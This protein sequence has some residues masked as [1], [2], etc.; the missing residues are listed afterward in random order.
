[1]SSNSEQCPWCG[2]QIERQKFNEIEAKIR[3]EEQKKLQ[4][5]K[6]ALQKNFELEKQKIEKRLKDEASE[7]FLNLNRQINSYQEQIKQLENNKD[8]LIKQAQKEASIKAAEERD[9]EIKHQRSLL[10]KN[11]ELKLLKQQEAFYKE[12]ENYQ[13]KITELGN[14]LQ[15]KNSQ[16]LE[17]TTINLYEELQNAFPDDEIK[18]IP[19][20]EANEKII[21]KVL[22]KGIDCGFIL[23]D[24][25]NRQSWQ[26]N[27]AVNLHKEQV[28]LI[29]DHS[30]LAT[31][32]FPKGKKELCVEDGVIV[33][34]PNSVI[35]LI[36]LLRK[37]MIKMC[38]Q[39]L[40]FQDRGTKIARLYEFIS[41]ESYD[42]KRQEAT[43]LTNEILE[44]EVTETNQ[45]RKMWEKRGS[46]LTRLKNSL[47]DVDAEI[48]E[49]LEESVRI[50]TK[51]STVSIKGQPHL[52][53]AI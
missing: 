29:A 13:K 14:Q 40:S 31:T 6:S 2:S 45:H 17:A 32:V 9:K 38:Q 37:T 25:K 27:F 8:E 52:R 18:Y 34:H 50:K 49:I 53:K 36:E 22:Y 19:N 30:I 21:H 15:K 26:K 35:H 5:A 44:L 33:A 1:M 43:L 41:S 7:K 10:E 48:N 28:N 3:I 12:R 24:S 16:E 46:L 11:H 51:T 20:G 47:S 39:G 42:Q 23:I 4:E